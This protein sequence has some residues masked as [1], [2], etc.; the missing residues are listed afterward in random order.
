[1]AKAKQTP[2]KQAG[3]KRRSWRVSSPKAGAKG[4][5]GENLIKHVFFTDCK[6]CQ[7]IIYKFAKREQNYSNSKF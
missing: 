1:M 7:S 2:K 6:L 4:Q 3:S 5:P